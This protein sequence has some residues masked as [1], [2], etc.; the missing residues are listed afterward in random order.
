[1]PT[2]ST[3]VAS[4]VAQSVSGP[5]VSGGRPT[6][7]RR[8][9]FGAPALMQYRKRGAVAHP[10]LVGSGARTCLDRARRAWSLCVGREGSRAPKLCPDP[11]CFSWYIV[12]MD[13][14]D[15]FAV[16]A[17]G[18]VL[19]PER[20]VAWGAVFSHF[21]GQG[22]R[23]TSRVRFLIWLTFLC[24]RV[25]LGPCWVIGGMSASVY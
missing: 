22:V 11:E 9:P 18:T 8:V 2:K 3:P 1:M 5:P 21:W 25:L 15:G 10:A 16:L 17:G 4:P 6:H 12:Y 19:P 23:A 20:W 7:C 24:F 13:F 14:S